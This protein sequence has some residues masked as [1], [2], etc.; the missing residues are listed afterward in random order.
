MPLFP[1]S[2]NTY[3]KA[4]GLPPPWE[5]RW[6]NSKKLP[7]FH[8]PD[9]KVSK[10]ESP[11]GSDAETLHAYI[12]ANFPP[13]EISA[14]HLLVKHKDSRKPFSWKEKKITRT[15]E[16]ARRILE[17]YE[18]RIKGGEVKLREL[19]TTESDCSSY[20]KGGNL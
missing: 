10:W 20:E 9:S 16:E 15:K 6:S 12:A 2:A 3:S 14:A 8:D 19:A 18:K 7:Y 4:T 5:V 17:G 11:T 1:V 13:G